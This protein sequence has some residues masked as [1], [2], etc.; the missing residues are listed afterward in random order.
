MAAQAPGMALTI[1]QQLKQAREAK[2]LSFEDVSHATKIS[3]AALEAM[4]SDDFSVFPTPAYRRS[5]LKLY[6][7]HLAVEGTEAL[8]AMSP[9]GKRRILRRPRPDFLQTDLD[10]SP[11]KHTI[12]IVKHRIIERKPKRSIV[13]LVLFLLLALMLPAFF[14]AGKRAGL[15]ERVTRDQTAE[16]SPAKP[17]APPAKSEAPLRAQVI[18]VAP[19]EMY[20]D[21]P[22]RV[23][24]PDPQMNALLGLDH[25]PEAAAARKRPQ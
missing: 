5:F 4:E 20:G 2:G 12:P 24:A 22:S 16:T 8:E 6:C 23:Y 10:L 11:G 18:T 15:R 7:L 13:G 17:Q 25:P 19:K 9:A 3:T 14:Y 1:G 21:T